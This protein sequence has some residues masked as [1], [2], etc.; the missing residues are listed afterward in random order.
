MVEERSPEEQA[1][2]DEHFRIHGHHPVP[3]FTG[4]HKC[5]HPVHEAMTH[6]M[7]TGGFTL[8]FP[9]DVREVYTLDDPAVMD[10]QA[11]HDAKVR[12]LK[13][14]IKEVEDRAKRDDSGQKEIF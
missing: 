11:R 10:Y 7:K 6:L 5:A 1:Y 14:K 4:K 12:E 2:W 8:E 13:G 3:D 9:F